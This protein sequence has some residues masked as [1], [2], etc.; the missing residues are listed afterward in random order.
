M[1]WFQFVLHVMLFPMLNVLYFYHKT[2]L[3]LLFYHLHDGLCYL[4]TVGARFVQW[5]CQRVAR[6]IV[7][8]NNVSYHVL[9]CYLNSPK[10]N[11]KSD[12]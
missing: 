8:N 4:L 10:A 6:D 12:T 5:S 7:L 3:L 11:Y 9:K 1:L 2:L